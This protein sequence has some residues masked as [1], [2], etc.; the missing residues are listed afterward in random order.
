MHSFLPIHGGGGGGGGG[1]KEERSIC[2][3]VKSITPRHILIRPCFNNTGVAVN[4]QSLSFQLVHSSSSHRNEEG[5]VSVSQ[6][7]VKRK[8][9][10]SKII[11]ILLLQACVLTETYMPE[12]YVSP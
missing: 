3:T 7:R 8:V 10:R 11:A 2:S 1:R 5:T 4:S 12:K 6:L 9:E